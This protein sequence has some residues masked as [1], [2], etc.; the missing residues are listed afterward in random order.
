MAVKLI[1]EEPCAEEPRGALSFK[2][3]L[4]NMSASALGVSMLTMPSVMGT[5]GGARAGFAGGLLLMPIAALCQAG[6]NITISRAIDLADGQCASLGA[7]AL[8]ALGRRGEVFATVLTSVTLLGFCSSQVIVLGGIISREMGLQMQ[9]SVAVA[10]LALV[11]CALCPLSDR[12]GM[13]VNVSACVI[14][15]CILLG[16]ASHGEAEHLS[17]HGSMAETLS[18]FGTIIFGLGF[19]FVVPTVK[20]SMVEPARAGMASGLAALVVSTV[21]GTIMVVGYTAWGDDVQANVLDDLPAGSISGIATVLIS[22]NMFI[23][24]VILMRT[25]SVGFIDMFGVRRL[26]VKVLIRVGQGLMVCA[27]AVAVPE[28]DVFSDFVAALTVVGG[29]YI[30]P[31]VCY[32]A[33]C[34]RRCGSL[35][36]AV[37]KEPG[38]FIA[39]AFLLLFG[40]QAAV[41]GLMKAWPELV[42][43]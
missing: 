30:L 42:H 15:L 6:A 8:A 10:G 43:H 36:C 41:F 24:Y 29:N 19:G 40:L 33:L 28:L 39:H 2:G 12:L 34:T 38:M 23:V 13:A 32:W 37:R 3:A 31:Q 20:S 16:A 1:D 17:V 11:P 9:M 27:L 18:S 22:I 7:L 25:A 35:A 21:F 26:R 5:K 14:I 4:L